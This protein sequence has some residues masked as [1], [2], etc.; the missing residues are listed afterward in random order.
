LTSQS[1]HESFLN[2]HC[3]IKRE[4]ELHES[5]QARVYMRVFSTF[6]PSSNENKSCMKVDKRELSC[7]KSDGNR[8]ATSCSNKTN[9][10]CSSQVA[11]S[12]LS[13][14]CYVQTISDLMITT[15]SRLVNNWEQAVRTH[16]LEKLWDF[17]A[18]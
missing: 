2:V 10:G 4:Q 18:R 8:L 6:I 5:W 3:L 9:T 1:L 17:Y 15:C 13:S 12:L 14:T 11:T 7:S 16:L